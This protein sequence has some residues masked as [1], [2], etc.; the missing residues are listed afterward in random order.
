MTKDVPFEDQSVWSETILAGEP[1][2]NNFAM[3][4]VDYLNI[5]MER[6]VTEHIR[7]EESLKRPCPDN[8]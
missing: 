6:K 1:R 5:V 2:G 8:V 3:A 4:A 7:R